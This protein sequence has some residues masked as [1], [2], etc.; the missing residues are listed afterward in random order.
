MRPFE[1][2]VR[3]EVA[4]L[5]EAMGFSLIDLNVFRSKGARQV[6]LVIYK[7]EGVS[8]ADCARVSRQV[9]P[10]LEIM[11]ELG[12]CSLEVSSPGIGRRLKDPAEYKIFQGHS[13]AVL[14]IDESE[15][16]RGRIDHADN[17]SLFLEAGGEIVALPY[18]KIKQVKLS[19]AKGEE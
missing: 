6:K 1:D 9:H 11:E 16:R 3:S 10:R 18:E 2:H 17:K 12:D 7:P 14:I 8:I 15:W 4:P 13:V 19:L 5:I